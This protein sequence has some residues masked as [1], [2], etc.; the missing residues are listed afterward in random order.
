MYL[1]SAVL[2]GGPLVLVLYTYLLYPLSLRLAPRRRTLVSPAEVREWPTVSITVPVFNEEAQ[3]RSK[4]ESLLLLDYPAEKRQIVV[5]S[6]ACT[7]GT[8]DIVREYAPRGVELL[9]MPQRSGKGAAEEAAAGM[10]RGEVVINT[11]A[12]TRIG[13]DSVRWLVAQFADPEVGVASGRDVSVSGVDGDSNRGEGGYVGYEMWIRERETRAGGIVGASGCFYAIRADLH[14]SFLPP[15]LSRD[16]A[17]A[18]VAREHGY[19][20]VSVQA[21]TCLVPRTTSL[22]REYRRKVRTIARGMQTLW[23]KRRLLDPFRYGTFAWMLWSHKVCR[24]LVPWSLVPAALG[25]ATLATSVPL[26]AW[27]LAAAG[28]CA[29]AGALGWRLSERDSVPRL[30]GIAAYLLAGNV[31]VV[32]ATLQAFTG[33]DTAVWEPTRRDIVIGR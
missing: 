18:M 1:I 29:G 16:F 14:R 21:A 17:A 26:A 7:D 8:D 32:R 30:L 27:T 19:R 22:W 24:W 25:L 13:R 5:I 20:A 31:A 10:L 9:R 11:D 2:I 28:V 12:S 4:L 33:D 15:A 6:D 3:I 23:Y